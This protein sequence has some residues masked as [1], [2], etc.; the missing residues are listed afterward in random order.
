ME[1]GYQLTVP[2]ERVQAFLAS[3]SLR[4]GDERF[5]TVV[6]QF[7]VHRGYLLQ[8]RAA[9]RRVLI[10]LPAMALPSEGVTY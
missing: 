4:F 5:A 10:S 8:C 1:L 7:G 9:L 6:G 3:E 2:D